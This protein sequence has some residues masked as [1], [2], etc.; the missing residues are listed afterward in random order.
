MRKRR[1]SLGVRAKELS[2]QYTALYDNAPS[3]YITLPGL[4]LLSYRENPA[5]RLNYCRST[6][7]LKQRLHGIQ[8]PKV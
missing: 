4:S 8:Q 2:N 7:L 6:A 5:S 1:H 3:Q